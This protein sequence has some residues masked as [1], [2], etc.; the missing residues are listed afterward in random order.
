MRRLKVL[1]SEHPERGAT[2]ILAA[3]LLV[4]ILGF[5]GLA[6]DLG[7]N[8]AKHAQLQNG[9][10][11]AA[12]ALA[13]EYAFEDDPCEA[14]KGGDASGWVSGN[15][16]NDPAEASGSVVCH[17]KEGNALAVNE[18][19]VV[20]SQTQE[21]WFMPVLGRDSSDISADA[22]VQFGVPGKMITSPVTIAECALPSPE[23]LEAETEIV[24]WFP[25]PSGEVDPEDA[26]TCGYHEEY[27]PGGF[28]VI[29]PDVEPCGVTIT[30]PVELPSAPGAS[31][32][33]DECM[34]PMI[35]EINFVPIFDESQNTG[36][37]AEYL[38]VEFAAI[39]IDFIG[40]GNKSYGTGGCPEDRPLWTHKNQD[41]CLRGT[42]MGLVSIEDFL[43]KELVLPGPED[44][45]VVA[46]L[47]D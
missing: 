33:T 31:G 39:R 16:N 42:F 8:Y 4:V 41:T 7:A 14:A 5:A 18:L 27:P 37:N 2:A 34:A 15:I 23:E 22:T 28:G 3:L 29:E 35:G 43:E 32:V 21:H 20:A 40:F 6:I 9:A 44:T 36:A 46:R 19:R 1:R 10:D 30:V 26:D 24:V 12:L 11:A 25:H 47:I 13:Q 45:A 38:I 17:D